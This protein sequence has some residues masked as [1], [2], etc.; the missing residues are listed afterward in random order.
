MT[1]YQYQ[2]KYGSYELYFRDR[3]MFATVSGAVGEKMATTFVNHVKALVDAAQPDKMWGYLGDLRQ[4]DG[5]TP[6]AEKQLLK[7]HQYAMLHGCVVDSYCS[8]SP[9]ALGQ[10]KRIRQQADITSDLSTHIFQDKNAAI[11]FIHQTITRYEKEI[12]KG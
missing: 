7:G 5:Y 8:D 10:L 4:C 12:N 1:P 6:E 11:L 9:L 2:D 3:I